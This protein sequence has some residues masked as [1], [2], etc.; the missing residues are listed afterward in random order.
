MISENM[1]LVRRALFECNVNVLPSKLTRHLKP[2]S[3][4]RPCILFSSLSSSADSSTSLN[5]FARNNARRRERKLTYSERTP[6]NYPTHF[7]PKKRLISP[8]L[9]LLTRHV[10]N[11]Q[12]KILTPNEAILSLSISG[13][14]FN[15]CFNPIL[16]SSIGAP[17]QSSLIESVNS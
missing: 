6:H 12:Q 11:R 17:P 10:R 2:N 4:L 3:S 1:F 13:H 9:D 7:S 5:R 16:K 8:R 15:T 14:S